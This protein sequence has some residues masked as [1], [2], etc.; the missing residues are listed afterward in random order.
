MDAKNK[1]QFEEFLETFM[2]DNGTM[3]PPKTI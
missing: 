1:I 2:K 3:L